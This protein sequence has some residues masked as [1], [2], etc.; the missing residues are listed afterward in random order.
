MTIRD[1][2][3]EAYCA[4][5]AAEIAASRKQDDKIDWSAVFCTAS[6]AAAALMACYI[7]L[8]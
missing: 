5:R 8:F 7:A 3:S 2:V 6:V 4:R 1:T